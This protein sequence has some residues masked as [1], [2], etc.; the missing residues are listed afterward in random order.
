MQNFNHS[1]R[2]LCH[3]Y[4]VIAALW[5]AGIGAISGLGLLSAPGLQ[6]QTQ[7][8]AQA[9]ASSDTAPPIPTGQQW[10]YEMRT[11]VAN[12][13]K[14]AALE[15]RFRDHTLDLFEKH[16]MRTVS[17]WRPVED[18][19][20]LIY[21]LA[22]PSRTEAAAAWRAFAA[23]PEWQAV[24]RASEMNGRLVA[25]ISRVFMTKTDYSP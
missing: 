4:T 5:L 7:P 25:S 23:D 16:G 6:A 3:R 8:A 14:M 21:V 24:A 18:T 15:T 17:F 12:P 1:L 22:H 2:L 9:Y 10:I 13:G 20:T 19:D 11:Y